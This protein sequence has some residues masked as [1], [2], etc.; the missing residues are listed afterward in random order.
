MSLLKE[1]VTGSG[2]VGATGANAVA[3]TRGS[4]FGGGVIDVKK[5][6]KK[7]RKMMRRS[8][9][10]NEAIAPG[11]EETNFDAASVLSKI[12][13]AEQKARA[14]G[15]TTAFG[16]ED[17]DGQIVKV[18]VK[19]DQAEDFE[20]ALA[21]AL[22]GEDENDD[23]ENSS[24]EIAEVIFKLKDRFEI[25]DVDWNT[26]E[27]DEDEEQEVVGD[28]EGGESA[29]DEDLDVD[30]ESGVEP[31]GDEAGG[32]LEAGADDAEMDASEDDAKSALQSVIDV[33]KADAEAKEAEAKAKEAEAKAKEAEYASQSASAKVQQEEQILDMETHNKAKADKQKEAKQLAQ[34]AKY[35]HETAVGAE[36]KLSGAETSISNEG[37]DE[38]EEEDSGHGI[39]IDDLTALIMSN[40]RANS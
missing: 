19:S 18:Y 7:K 24:T 17:E 3:G 4:L 32:D 22:A 10:V 16:L 25:I 13:N 5:P 26:F 1:M 28:E 11:S 39:S 34:L 35:K 23:D 30:G 21:V 14:N 2:A 31:N 38:D 6:K 37:Y 33:M 36:T 29:G 9:A 8:M 20:Q 15:D 27:G 12:D 40:L